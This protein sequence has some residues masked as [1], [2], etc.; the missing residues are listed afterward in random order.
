LIT[1]QP[2][3]T[4]KEAGREGSREGSRE[5]REGRK[6]RKEG[7]GNNTLFYLS[8]RYKSYNLFIRYSY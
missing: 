8:F 7:K 5:G 6:G 2:L 4:R 1:S 3:H